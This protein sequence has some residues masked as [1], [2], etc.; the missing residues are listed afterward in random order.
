M[1]CELNE[2]T[3]VQVNRLVR[4]VA[5]R[6]GQGRDT[7]ELTAHARAEVLAAVRRGDHRRAG[8]ALT[9][10]V[11]ARARGALLDLFRKEAR[12]ATAAPVPLEGLPARAPAFSL[13][14][15]LADLPGEAAEAVRAALDLAEQGLSP[16]LV[17]AEVARELRDRGWGTDR[18]RKAFGQLREA[19]A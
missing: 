8:C 11:Y 19:L 15:F 6:L 16:K 3:A 4:S 1:E 17:K 18:V 10:F 14:A 13:A 7:E 5:L 12:R 2:D 9:T